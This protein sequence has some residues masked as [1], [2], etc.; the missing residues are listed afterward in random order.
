LL[1]GE[2]NPLDSLGETFFWMGRLDESAANYK[3]A[4]EIKPDF[5]SAIFAVGY[6]H[7]L[8][9]EYAEG[10]K[11]FD[12]LIAATPPGIRREGYLFKGFYRYWLGSLKDFDGALREA[13]KISEPGYAWGV[14]FINW[15]KAFIHYDRGEL[16]QSRRYNENWLA[17]FIQ[18]HPDRKFYYQEA[19]HFLSGL[20]EL[21]AGHTV[22][23]KNLL[24]K[25]KSLHKEMTPYRKDW[26]AF[27]IKFLGAE[28]ALEGGFPEKAIAI[29]EEKTPFRNESM[30]YYS[31]W[32]LYNMPVMK[33][34][35]PRAYEQKGDIDGAIAEYERLI[36]F[37]P[38]NLDQRLIHPK[39]HYKLG[40]LYEQKGYKGKAI[41]QYKKF[42]DLWKDAD[43]GQPEVEDAKK[44]LAAL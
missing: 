29:F 6:I 12:N 5:D 11:W 27:Y 21:K 2:A 3:H 24:A 19:Y 35:V 32:I 28:L 4:L 9:E 40:R 44:R 17:D 31:S 30:Y 14:P 1:P 13:E 43:P 39:Y 10:L 18:E 7:A 23:A 25:M 37:D 8:K 42:L 38:Q 16:E 33:D 22:S 26:V 20:L 34:V 15:M 41:D 36:T